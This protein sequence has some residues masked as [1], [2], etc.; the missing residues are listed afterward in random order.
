[1]FKQTPPSRYVC[2]IKGRPSIHADSIAATMTLGE[3][4]ANK[5][6]ESA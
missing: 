1:M 2:V 5:I 3:A 4:A 6:G